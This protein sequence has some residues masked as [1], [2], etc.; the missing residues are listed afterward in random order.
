MI[1]SLIPLYCLT[2]FVGSGKTTV[3]MGILKQYPEKKIGV[4]FTE[5]AI[6]NRQDPSREEDI[7]ID[8][9]DNGSLSCVC[10]E[11]ALPRALEY[12]HQCQPEM[13]FVEVSGLSDPLHVKHILQSEQNADCMKHYALE[14]IICLVDADNFMEQIQDVEMVGRQLCHCHLAVINKADL[15]A[16]ELLGMLKAQIHRINADC[17]IV[18]CSYGG[19]SLEMLEHD[20]LSH[21][22]SEEEDADTGR[23]P[24]SIVLNCVH[25]LPRDK[26]VAFIERF[27]PE[28]YRI[29]GF[30]LFENGWSQVDVVGSRIHFAPC[31]PHS[32]SRLIFISKIGHALSKPLAESWEEL[33]GLPMQ[34]HD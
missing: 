31:M 24:D 1:Q 27:I 11:E 5:P 7:S 25:R 6:Y 32:S 26:V 23:L 16:P 10:E 3:L 28:T 12:M 14:G 15:V 8:V 30:C 4:I 21:P 22:T 19:F 34:L 33:I 9:C 17:D 18:S 20:L 2:G 29:K 13:V